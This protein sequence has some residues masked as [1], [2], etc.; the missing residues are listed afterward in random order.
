MDPSKTNLGKT[1]P[2]AT[3]SDKTKPVKKKKQI[4]EILPDPNEWRRVGPMIWIQRSSAE[5]YKTAITFYPFFGT[6]VDSSE[7]QFSIILD[8]IWDLFSI[9][10][11]KLLKIVFS[12]I[13][14]RR[15][16][17]VTMLFGNWLYKPKGL[18]GV[19]PVWSPTISVTHLNTSK[20]V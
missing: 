4:H 6:V 9:L 18:I 3:F 11:N 12:T 19:N 13:S 15:K 14:F 1:K 20:L 5:A 17:K 7:T 2:H 10:S 16:L 8:Q